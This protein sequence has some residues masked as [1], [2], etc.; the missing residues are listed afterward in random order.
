MGLISSRLTSNYH[1]GPQGLEV[2]SVAKENKADMAD[3]VEV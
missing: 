3:Q 1:A 2:N